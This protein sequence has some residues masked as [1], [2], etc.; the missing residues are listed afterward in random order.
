M[1]FPDQFLFNTLPARL[2]LLI[3]GH[4]AGLKKESRAASGS[5]QS[6]RDIVMSA[7]GTRGL[8][9]LAAPPKRCMRLSRPG[10]RS[11]REANESPPG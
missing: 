2:N 8:Q 6:G 1:N 5:L 4:K 11:R 9:K 7:P 10:W 3:A